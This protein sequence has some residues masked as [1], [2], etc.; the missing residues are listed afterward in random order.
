MTGVPLNSSL[1]EPS[2]RSL[3]MAAYAINPSGQLISPAGDLGYS[4]FFQLIPVTFAVLRVAAEVES[5]PAAVMEWYR[6]T[7]IEELGQFTAEQLVASGRAEV[8]IAFLRTIL[9]G[10]R[11]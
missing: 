6:N 1:A 10:A 11:A 5:S 2:L 8:V 3:V 9:D 4:A 7:P